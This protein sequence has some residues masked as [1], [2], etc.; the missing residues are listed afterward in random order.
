MLKF[1]MDLKGKIPNKLVRK[2]QFKDQ[3]FDAN[4]NFL[5]QEVDKITERVCHAPPP[6]HSS[7]PAE[8]TLT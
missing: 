2:G 1:F 4:C 8:C 6:P 7:P 3:H 5:C